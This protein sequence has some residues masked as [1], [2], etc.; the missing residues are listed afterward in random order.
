[1]KSKLFKVEKNKN[2]K[3]KEKTKFKKQAARKMGNPK[4][5]RCV[6]SQRAERS[7]GDAYCMGQPKR[8]IARVK[9]FF[10]TYRW[11][12]WVIFFNFRGNF[13]DVPQEAIDRIRHGNCPQSYKILIK[14]ARN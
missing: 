8:G 4:R 11:H 3:E 13:R 2:R 1:L 14:N 9:R 7:I 12:W 5:A 6:F 10:I